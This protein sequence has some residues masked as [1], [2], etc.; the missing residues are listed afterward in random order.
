MD[1]EGARE[2]EKRGGTESENQTYAKIS[3][4]YGRCQRERERE[5]GGWGVEMVKIGRMKKVPKTDRQR[6][7]SDGKLFDA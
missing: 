7:M 3:L 5:T 2:R 6:P 1:T 4:G